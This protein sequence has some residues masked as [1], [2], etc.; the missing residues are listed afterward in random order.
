MTLGPRSGERVNEGERTMKTEL[1]LKSKGALSGERDWRK[2]D[3]SNWKEMPVVVAFLADE[4]LQE[5]SIVSTGT[6]FIYTF[7]KRPA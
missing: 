3:E 2:E 7:Q 4:E 1:W 5:M 6:G